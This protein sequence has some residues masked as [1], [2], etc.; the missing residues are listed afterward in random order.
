MMATFRSLSVRAT[1]LLLVFVT[2]GIVLMGW[3][4]Y[5]QLS[6]YTTDNSRMRIERAAQAAVSLAEARLPG[7]L[8]SERDA[9]GLPVVIRLQGSRPLVSLAEP[10]AYDDLVR[11]IG[12]TTGGAANVF[13]WNEETRAFDRFA[14]TFRRPDGS[15][16]PPFSIGVD[17]PAYEIV[18]ESQA[19]RG[20]VPVMGRMRYAYLTPIVF[21]GGDLGGLL[22]IDVGWSDDLTTGQEVLKQ[23]IF[24]IASAILAITVA[25]GGR[26]HWG[27]LAPIPALGRA[28]HRMATGERGI[29]IPGLDRRDEIADLARGLDQVNHLHRE[30]EVLAY[31]DPLTGLGNLAHFRQE[32]KRACAREAW[33][34]SSA[35]LL[36]NIDQFR[37]INEGFGTGFGD[38]VLIE[39]GR[40][41]RNFAGSEN[42]LPARTGSD[43][44]ALILH[45]RAPDQLD[46]IIRNLR[47]ALYEPMSFGGVGIEFTVRL[48]VVSLPTNASTPDDA[49]RNVQL[50]LRAA[51]AKGLSSFVVFDPALDARARHDHDL[52]V[53]L[54]QTLVD[55]QGLGVHFQ[56]QV[57]AKA[58]E[59][60]GLEALVCWPQADGSMIPPG[61]FIPIAEANGLIVELGSW[62]LDET[63]R[64]MRQWIDAAI[65]VPHVSINVSPAQIWQPD[66]VKSV[67]DALERHRIPP[68]MIY[69]EV[70]E[71]LF[72]NFSEDRIQSVFASLR[73][74]GVKIALDDFGTGYS[75]LGYLHRI[76]IDQIK[77]DRIFAVDIDKDPAKQRLFKGITTLASGLHLEVV[78]EG[79]ETES[80]ARFIM[81]TG[82]DAIQG[83]FFARPCTALQVAQE[84]DNVRSLLSRQALA[85]KADPATA[86]TAAL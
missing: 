69:L 51:E 72:V 54:R 27:M 11:E 70:T 30:L 61:E 34:R 19:F 48:G 24:W 78:V 32:L 35:V 53:A 15:M 79:A 49:E 57:S 29:V 80:E 86:G 41:I 71:G 18:T 83:Y 39:V 3:L 66:F 60:F 59:I 25:I 40:R 46:E 22:A 42:P 76:Q 20:D 37:T 44:F 64:I 56:I 10:E 2:I 62:V 21:P 73:A 43:E 23:R 55:G 4:S 36:F 45:N 31:S 82:C 84:M 28:A 68:Q 38:R 50:A 81:Q 67:R 14:T 85:Q 6:E 16:P 7:D 52:S 47:N 13:V 65:P 33:T 58:H 17:H 63:C 5:Q 75:S 8:I 12:R 1:I 74:I 9:M 26:L 77:I